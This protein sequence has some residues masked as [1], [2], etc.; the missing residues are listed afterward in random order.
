MSF[1]G[2]VPPAFLNKSLHQKICQM[3][4]KSLA[5]FIRLYTVTIS[6]AEVENSVNVSG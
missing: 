1:S 3:L 5:S 2:C 4:F 6:L